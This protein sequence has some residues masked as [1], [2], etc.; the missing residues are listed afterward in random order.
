VLILLC[1][2]LTPL[3]LILLLVEGEGARRLDDDADL[4]G[5]G[6]V[7][8]FTPS[9]VLGLVDNVGD[10]RLRVLPLLF[11]FT[12]DKLNEEVGRS[13]DADLLSRLLLLADP[14]EVL[15]SDDLVGASKRGLT[16]L[17]G[18]VNEAFKLPLHLV[19]VSCLLLRA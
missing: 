4:C 6:L 2:G 15:A 5:D 19:Y 18:S 12:D 14:G 8:V 11:D 1:E 9:D 16:A 13:L 3:L 10:A 17:L 7:V